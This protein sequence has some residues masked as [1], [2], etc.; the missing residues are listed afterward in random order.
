MSLLPPWLP[1][2]FPAWLP[3]RLPAWL[4]WA[5]AALWLLRALQCT[6]NVLAIPRL[7][8]GAPPPEGAE[9]PHV[10]VVVP[11]RN[12]AA[13][14]EG[15][16][17]RLLRQQGVRLE[18]VVVDDRSTDDTGARLD[19]LAASRPGLA[20]EHVR[21]LPPGWLGK[22]HA[23][24]VGASRPAG[25]GGPSR[26]LLFT[27]ADIWLAPDVLARAVA[28]AERAGA[29]HVALIPHEQ[30]RGAWGTAALQAML[31]GLSDLV[32]PTNR[33]ERFMGVG[34][35]NL[36]RRDAFQA[37]GGY[38][39]LRL[40]VV[41][42]VYTGF[43]MHAAGHRSR[44]LAAGADV[45]V[46]YAQTPA[47]FVRV[48][49]KNGFA[50]YGYSVARVL[51]LLLLY[52]TLTLGAVL[53]P[54][55]GGPAGWAALLAG[56]VGCVPAVLVARR[57]GISPGPAPLMPLAGWVLLYGVARSLVLTSARGGV[58]WRDTLYPLA[59]LRAARRALLAHGAR[60]RAARPPA[61]GAPAPAAS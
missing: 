7:P 37:A 49:E 16:V 52:L 48:V 43:L 9:P 33:G 47:E 29:A 36:V 56:L 17:D 32:G 55:Q 28:E 58:R 42:D 61:Q 50:V 3:A 15:T 18:V 23:C 41:D 19:R 4:L 34:A 5:V 12:E 27:D 1:A 30:P 57:T 10:A 14:V 13:R 54:L 8:P 51:G 26:W 24:H 21:E 39:A 25:P 31:L 35:F 22:C 60:L 59:D 44:I 2:W 53:G 20:V 40:E 6:R 11:A 38:E 46:S 45:A